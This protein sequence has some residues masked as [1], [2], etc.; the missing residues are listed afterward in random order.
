MKTDT[1]RSQKYPHAEQEPEILLGEVEFAIKK[2]KSNKAPGGDGV[3]A[4]MLKAGGE[5]LTRKLWVICQA[6]RST[7]EWPDECLKSD[8]ILLPK[9]NA[10]KDCAKH[11][12]VSLISH[13]SKILL[14]IFQRRLAYYIHPNIA[15]E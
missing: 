12:T 9:V 3:T 5:A 10:T 11:R 1:R 6:I 2:L 14:Q 13:A 4:E 8:M 15:E 7:G